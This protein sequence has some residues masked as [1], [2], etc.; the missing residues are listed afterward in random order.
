MITEAQIL[1]KLETIDQYK[2]DRLVTHLLYQ[3]AYSNIVQ[4]NCFI[5][6]FG[7]NPHK[8]RTIKSPGHADA[9]IRSLG[10]HIETSV[11]EEWSGKFKRDVNKNKGRQIKT[12]VFCT[13]QDTGSNNIMH[14]RVNVPAEKYCKDELDCEQSFIIGMKELLYP[15]QD[16]KFSYLRREYLGIPEEHFYSPAL[17]LQSIRNSLGFRI[18]IE[19]N[20]L[21][22]LSVEVGK[23]LGFSPN[24]LTILHS[25]DYITLLHALGEWANAEYERQSSQSI[26][27]DHCFI[28]W[29]AHAASLQGVDHRELSPEMDTFL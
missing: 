26:T 3:G 25:D 16:P 17:F 8:Q 15:L 23:V 19:A 1:G 9:E 14:N 4:P 28:N 18:S 2:L 21:Q 11:N 5:E 6:P 22:N 27:T 10:V 7:T 12:F 24:E 20:R 13:N 29:P